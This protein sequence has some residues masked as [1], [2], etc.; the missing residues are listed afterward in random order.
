MSAR[1]NV[2]I[3]GAAGRDF[4]NFLYYWR[5]RP[6]YRV[7]AF[8]AN[9]IEGI[10]SRPFPKEL[11][12]SPLYPED[13]PIFPESQLPEL[14]KKHNVD[15]CDIAYSD[16]S[17]ADV[18]HIAAVVNA[19]GANFIV[20]S[21]KQTWLESKKPVISVC[22]VRTGC[23]K[24]QTTRWLCDYIKKQGKKPVVIRHPMPYGDLAEQ[25]VQRYETLEDMKKHKCTIEEQ[26][27]YEAHIEAGNL[28]FAGV[29]YGA[30][31]SEAEKEA[32]VLIWDG[33]NND[34]P[35]YRPDLSIVVADALRPGH[36]GE[37]YP[38]ETNA[39]MADLLLI[40]KVNDATPEQLA[41]AE[42]SLKKLNSTAHILRCGSA[43]VAEFE[44]KKGAE[45]EGRIR[46]KRCLI[47]EDG[48]TLSHGGMSTG[49]GHSLAVTLGAVV[50]PAGPFAV[51]SIK[52][53][54][55]KYPHLGG[56]VVPA[57]GYGEQQ[58]KDLC[59]TIEAAKDVDTVVVGT[60]V[61]LTALFKISKP[62][63]RVRYDLA[64]SNPDLIT[65]ALQK[66]ISA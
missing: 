63:V 45:A 49:A 21:P 1:K 53:T 7:V 28:L 62:V 52:A 15:V 51:G 58:V 38:G 6:E 11:A 41:K 18:G 17:H 47:V 32:D 61:D 48:P 66:V 16:L 43:L 56:L 8:T 25:R 65:Q 29:D 30:I 14:I 19:A 57:M 26:E 39:R 44:G 54:Y 37:Y 31:L 55:D 50:V 3:I 12:D 40:N 35:F 20:L 33:G 24:S 59:A 23:G 46:G 2:I 36:E 13:I 5:K 64:P 34:A 4:H 60:P 9:Q 27:E 10:D 22:A 42:A